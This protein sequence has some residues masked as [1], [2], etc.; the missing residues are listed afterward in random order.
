MAKRNSKKKV[1]V[2]SLI[3]MLVLVCLLLSVGSLFPESGFPSWNAVFSA[4]DLAPAP[5]TVEGELEV[6]FIDVGNADCTLV[7][8]GEHNLLI[9]AGERGDGDEILQ[10]LNEQGVAKL[11][12][13]IAT[14]PH[15]DHIGSMAEV[16]SGLPVDRF[17]MAFMPEKDTPT[18]KVYLNMLEALDDK[19]IPLDEAEPG[20]VYDLGEAKLQLL[21]PINEA[22]DPNAMSVV[23]RLTFGSRAFLF[24][25]DA[26]TEEEEDILNAGYTVKADVLKVAHHG[27]DTSNGLSWLQAVD[28]TYSLIPCGEGNSYGHPMQSV[29]DDL[30]AE[31][32]IIYRSDIHGH[33]VFRCDG[34]ELSAVGM[35]G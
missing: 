35:R 11:D 28:P 30:E 17:I 10:Y 5:T 31:Q 9:D 7:R 18:S 20:R 14:H 16:L 15:A 29:L 34:T 4:T 23:A 24:T 8:Q 1:T 21:G 27:S 26:T 22:S 19:N 6:H 13:V 25:G 3:T 12:L 32:S 2:T 33:V